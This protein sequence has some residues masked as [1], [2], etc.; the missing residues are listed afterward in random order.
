MS[1][2]FTAQ[3]LG[4]YKRFFHHRWYFF[5]EKVL[6]FGENDIYIKSEQTKKLDERYS[7]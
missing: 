2:N 5:Y 7:S 4:G 3:W 6:T 1:K